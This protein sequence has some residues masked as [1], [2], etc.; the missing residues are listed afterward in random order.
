MDYIKKWVVLRDD[1]STIDQVSKISIHDVHNKIIADKR[2]EDKKDIIDEGLI[3]RNATE[4][5]KIYMKNIF[6]FKSGGISILYKDR[7]WWPA[8]HEYNKQ[9]ALNLCQEIRDE[10]RKL[11]SEYY[12]D[13][14]FVCDIVNPNPV[15]RMI[16]KKK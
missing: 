11:F 4:V 14:D 16:S 7:R 12:T 9:E 2:A 1:D 6:E 3:L 13:V 8:K 5:E 10:Y 15:L